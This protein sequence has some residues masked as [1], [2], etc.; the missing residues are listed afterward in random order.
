MN[1]SPGAPFVF[2]L[3]IV[4][5]LAISDGVA[6]QTCANPLYA[7]VDQ[8]VT[9]N[10]CGANA[11]PTQNH[12]TI[13]TPG[14]DSVFMVG[15]GPYGVSGVMVSADPHKVFVFLCS[16]CGANAECTESAESGVNGGYLLYP[17]DGQQY[18]VVVDSPDTTCTDFQLSVTGPLKQDP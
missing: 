9:G 7:T 13:L 6:A 3:S 12:G 18:Y 15:G 10:T 4:S 14:G 2:A 11:M 17:N 1:D 8:T 16:G 5:G